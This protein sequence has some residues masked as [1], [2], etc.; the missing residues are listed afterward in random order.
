[1]KYLL[2]YSTIIF[3]LNVEKC[4][5]NESTFGFPCSTNSLRGDFNRTREE[6]KEK[7]KKKEIISTNYAVNFHLE[8]CQSSLYNN[9]STL[10]SYPGLKS[11]HEF[12]SICVELYSTTHFI[13]VFVFT[14]QT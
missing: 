9:Y 1:M 5:V 3:K 14:Q 13:Y 2:R 4:L 8:T 7:K 10:E 12:A 11:V 6:K